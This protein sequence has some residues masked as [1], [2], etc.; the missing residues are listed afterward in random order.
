M[1]RVVGF[2]LVCVKALIWGLRDNLGRFVIILLLIVHE[3][4]HALA[5]ANCG[6]DMHLVFFF[7]FFFLSSRVWLGVITNPAVVLKELAD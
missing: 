7:L 5:Q 6:I 3:I 2:A 1:I 4:R